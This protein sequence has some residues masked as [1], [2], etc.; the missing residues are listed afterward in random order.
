MTPRLERITVPPFSE[1]IVIC[2]SWP[3]C[4][5]VGDCPDAIRSPVVRRIL[6]GMMAAVALIGAGL[7]YVGV[8]T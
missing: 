4:D 6:I 5:C 2:E 8:R 1:E 3:H 7:I